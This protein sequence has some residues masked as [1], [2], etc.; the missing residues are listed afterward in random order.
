MAGAARSST[1]NPNAPMFV[2]AAFRQVEDFSPEW[3]ELVKTSAWFRDYWLSEH[4]E[5]SFAADEEEEDDVDIAN[6]LPDSLVFGIDEEFLD[7]EFDAQLQELV[8]S[9]SKQETE[10]QKH[11]N[12]I[13][14][15]SIQFNFNLNSC[16]P[17][18]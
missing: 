7:L 17:F 14:K 3:W 11:Q 13:V 9:E 12:G 10:E 16:V 1:L 5:D 4:E 18:E 6:W 8:E 15:H 2:P